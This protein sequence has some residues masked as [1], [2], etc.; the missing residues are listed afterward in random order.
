MFLGCSNLHVTHMISRYAYQDDDQH[1]PTSH[2]QE[3]LRF[4]TLERGTALKERT[5]RRTREALE[6]FSVR[7]GNE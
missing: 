7:K 2:Q 4:L 3:E 5:R 6:A 1:V